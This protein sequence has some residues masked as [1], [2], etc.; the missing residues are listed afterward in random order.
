MYAAIERISMATT[1]QV[2]A[3]QANAQH[4]TGPVTPEGKA[5]ASQNASAF[6]LFSASAFIRSDEEEIYEEF[7]AAW[8]A[9]LVPDGPL[10]ET[11]VGEL[12]QA[13]WRLRR[14]TLLETAAHGAFG[15]GFEMD[16]ATPAEELD[17]IQASIDRARTTAQRALQRNL[18][19]LRRIQTDRQMRDAAPYG[20]QAHAEFGAASIRDVDNFV[21]QIVH[22]YPEDSFRMSPATQRRENSKQTQSTAAPQA[23]S[24]KRTQSEPPPTPRSAPC[25]CG[26]GEKFKR[27]CGKNAPPVLSFAA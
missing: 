15:T 11:L 18:N 13:A 2:L 22:R 26:S 12:V 20:H 14:C 1:A 16:A 27:C 4:S 24:A 9:R 25:P 23:D 19:E 17:R 8:N 21:H 5:R 7:R 6:G 3:N 10:E